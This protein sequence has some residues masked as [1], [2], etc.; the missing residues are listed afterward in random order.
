MHY[1]YK[2]QCLP[3]RAAAMVPDQQAGQ[4]TVSLYRNCSA[5]PGVCRG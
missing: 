2:T 1:R 4:I 3:L 5:V